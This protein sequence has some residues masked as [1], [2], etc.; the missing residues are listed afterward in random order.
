MRSSTRPGPDPACAPL[1][2]V[3]PPAPVA[4]VAA[5]AVAVALSLGLKIALADPGAGPAAAAQARAEALH[6]FLLANAGPLQPLAP[7][8]TFA[9][10]GCRYAAFPSSMRG[11]LD[12]NALARARRGDR[13]AYVYKGRVTDRRPTLALAFDIIAATAE[14]PFRGGV[15]PGYVVL[16]A[17]ACQTLPDLPW[18]RLA[19]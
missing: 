17:K 11:N 1:A 18:D 15:E 10:G 8:W 7:G 9:R 13:V 16:V 14:R 19:S 4:L 12:M 5:V 3:A 2:P 6:R